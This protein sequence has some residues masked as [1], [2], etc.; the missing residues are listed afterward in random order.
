MTRLGLA[1]LLGAAVALGACGG[2]SDARP[3]PAAAPA[4]GVRTIATGLD[5]P[6]GIAFLPGGD[7]LVGERD[8]GRI[9]R[10]PAGGGTPR[11]VMRVPDVAATGE[12]GLLGLAVSPHYADDGLV[13]G[14]ATT[15][16]DN[17]IVRFRLGGPVQ[18]I[19][20]GLRAGAIHDGGGLAFGP[21]GRL[22]AG[23][24]ETGDSGLAQD[25]SARNGKILR[26]DPDG[27]VPADNPFPGSPV[28]SL[29]HRNV[30]GLA[31]DPDGRLWATE[32]GQST[33][34]EVN[35]IRKGANYGWPEV[36]G[37]G[38]TAGG[39]FTDPAMTWT[40][41]AEASPSGAAIVDGTLY[42]GALQGAAVL[43]V[44]LA[45]DRAREAAPILTGHGR[46]RTVAAA[47]D[48]S[49]WATT[50]NTD[51]RGIPRAGDDRILAFR[52]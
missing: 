41:T 24:G 20:T 2:G 27:S 5:A 33:T 4:G 52:P 18:P 42:V 32:F 11:E 37:R 51:G 12:G 10:V 35:L 13:Y 39:R 14:Y 50:S 45:G 25:R 6:W 17:R 15:E 43:R 16:R 47:P 30:Q 7:A 23:V 31:W 44:R 48:G 46:I 19:L 21:D 29:G 36:E 3:Q 9:L 1:V 49:V 34:D 26:I 38:D 8:S 40:P 28:W 22:Y